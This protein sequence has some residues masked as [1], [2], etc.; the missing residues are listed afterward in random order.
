MVDKWGIFFVNL[1]PIKG[2]EQKGKRPV[3]VVSNEAV[4]RNLPVCTVIPFSSYKKNDNIYPTEV[5]VNKTVT[6]LYKDSIL[7]IQQIRTIDQSRIIGT[8]V[9]EIKEES[10]KKE[11]NDKIRD[12]FDL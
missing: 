6:S 9:G 12:Y 8:K 7:M 2:S 1:D 11:I 10:I 4:N 3:L 5:M